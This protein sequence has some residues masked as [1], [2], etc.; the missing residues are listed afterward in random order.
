MVRSYCGVAWSREALHG[1][2]KFGPAKHSMASLGALWS[3]DVQWGGVW[4]CLVRHGKLS[5]R[6]GTEGSGFA[7]LSAVGQALVRHYLG[8]A[9]SCEAG[10]CMARFASAFLRL[11]IVLLSRV[12]RGPVRLCPATC[13]TVSQGHGYGGI[14]HE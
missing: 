8:W 6:H 11:G 4:S 13:G 1:I 2:A 3:C 12:W 10:R 5:L 14:K 9:W 7:R